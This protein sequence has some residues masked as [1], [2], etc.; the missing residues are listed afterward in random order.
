VPAYT[1]YLVLGKSYLLPCFL[2]RLSCTLLSPS[3]FADHTRT[4]FPLVL[5]TSY[6]P[7][8]SYFVDRT[9]YLLSP[10]TSY[11]KSV[12][13]CNR[14]QIRIKKNPLR[15]S[16]A[17]Q[18][19]LRLCVFAVKKSKEPHTPSDR[20]SLSQSIVGCIKGKLPSATPSFK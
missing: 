18:A 5:R 14:F 9:S 11:P 8:P 19:F 16:D 15:L 1:A 13:A 17:R 7:S 4:F 10:R 12:I 2:I 20:G 6:L 3:Y